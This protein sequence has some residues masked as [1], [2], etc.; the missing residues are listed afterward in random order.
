VRD[1]GVVINDNEDLRRQR[2]AI[3]IAFISMVFV[4]VVAGISALLTRSSIPR[5]AF[6]LAVIVAVSGAIASYVAGRRLS[7]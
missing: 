7:S 1:G 3:R 6:T 2:R 5:A 4:A